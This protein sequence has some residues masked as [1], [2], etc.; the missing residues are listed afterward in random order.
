MG[1]TDVCAAGDIK[2][3]L[4][5]N[6]LN[7]YEISLPVDVGYNYTIIATD[8]VVSDAKDTYGLNAVATDGTN[9][10][11]WN[12]SYISVPGYW[13]D[14]DNDGT[15]DVWVENEY[16]SYTSFLSNF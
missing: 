10:A 12:N 15:G 13:E 8:N 16:S 1:D 7:R 6:T 4:V 11:S 14:T 2:L 3:T 5:P 9:N